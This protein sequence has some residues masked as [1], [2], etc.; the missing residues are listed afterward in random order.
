MWD[1][2]S[3]LDRIIQSLITH[4]NVKFCCSPV[5][6]YRVDADKGFNFSN[7]DDAFVCQ[8]KNH[9]QV[10]RNCYELNWHVTTNMILKMS[11]KQG[12]G[13]CVELELVTVVGT[14]TGTGDCCYTAHLCKGFHEI[15]WAGSLS[16]YSDWLRAGRSGKRIPVEVRFSAPV[17]TSPGAHPASCT[18]CTGSFPGVKSGRGVTLTPHP[19]LC[20]G[21]ERVELCLYSPYGPYS[22][23]RASM[24]VQG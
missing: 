3:V 12:T 10:R 24:P 6:H 19:F 7:A 23:Y 14:G 11:C 9:F 22:L 15:L 4:Y 1:T 16:W 17:Q 2:G 21:H 13:S 8:K 18:M 20:R 5:P